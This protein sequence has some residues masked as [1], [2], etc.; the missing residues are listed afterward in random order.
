MKIFRAS[1]V[2]LFWLALP[3]TVANGQGDNHTLY[4]DITVD[5]SKVDGL[6]PISIEVTLYT[7]SRV[8]ISRQSVPT[9]GRYRFNNLAT[10]FYELVLELE[11][12]EV[13]R[14]R[15]DLSSPLLAERRQDLFLEWNSM[16]STGT[17]PAI[18]S[19]RDRYERSSAN[20]KLFGRA[21]DAVNKR[22]YEAAAVALKAITASDPRDFQAWTELAN[23]HLL[24]EKYADAENEYLRAIDL[25]SNFFPALLNLGRLE[26]ATRKYDVAIAVLG[27]V[28]RSYPESADANYLIGESYLQLRQGSQ[29]VAYLNQAIRLDPKGMAD[30]HLRLATLYHRSRMRDKAAAEY[31]AFLKKKPDYADRKKL[32]EYISANKKQ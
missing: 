2:F 31:Q 5:E 12:R 11:G 1:L 8:I 29:A 20:A 4:G 26:V 28:I 17:K 7:E 19:V 25:H 27:R 23:I 13:A 22:N 14:M 3:V 30:V 21:N 6:K 16:T 10:G 32:E 15:V 18:I 9:N 24:Q